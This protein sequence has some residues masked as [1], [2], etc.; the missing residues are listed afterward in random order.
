M[1]IFIC[2]LR[3]N[4]QVSPGNHEFWFQFAA[5]QKRFAMPGGAHNMFYSFDL[6]LTHFVAIDTESEADVAYMSPAQ[7]DWL[8]K[9]LAN[10]NGPARGPWTIVFG[11]RPLYCSNHGGQDVPAGNKV[12]ARSRSKY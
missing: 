8:Q 9:D 12:L 7:L 10:N 1:F 2:I 5:Y 6:S 11:H 4:I 3:D